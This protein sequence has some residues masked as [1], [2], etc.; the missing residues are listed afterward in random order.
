MA[1]TPQSTW[2]R[3]I[4][5]S[6]FSDQMDVFRWIIAHPAESRCCWIFHDH[7]K[8]LTEEEEHTRLMPDGSE[9]DFKIGDK[10]PDHYHVIL[11]IP[12][13]LTA[14]TFSKRYGNYVHFQICSDPRNYIRYFLHDT[15]ISKHK[16]H[17]SSECIK[18]DAELIHDLLKSERHVLPVECL[19]RYLAAYDACS[20][21]T[22][23]TIETLLVSG[24]TDTVNSVMSHSYFYGR[25]I[26]NPF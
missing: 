11:K 25:F 6:D 14:D 23:L 21:D 1:H 18:G 24:D 13:K 19:Q 22:R 8:V 3:C 15:F 9:K 2:F 16:Y 26:S 10:K 17:Y 5:Q 4:I 7:D 20:G 12:K